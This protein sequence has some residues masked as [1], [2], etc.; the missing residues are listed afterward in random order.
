MVLVLVVAVGTV[1]LFTS[2]GTSSAL[3]RYIGNRVNRD[4]RLFSTV[5]VPYTEDIAQ[6]QARI[7]EINRVTGDIIAV[8][9][10]DGKIIAATDRTLIGQ[11]RDVVLPTGLSE[12]EPIFI[13]R[14]GPPF[15][16]VIS[17]TGSLTEAYPL[18]PYGPPMPIGGVVTAPLPF[19]GPVSGT[20]RL[21]L[22]VVGRN[23]RP[24]GPIEQ[25]LIGSV[26]NALL[27]AVGL[28]GLAA[29]L[30]TI[31]LS[32]RILGPVES[33]T[34]AARKMEQGDLGQRVRVR[35][36]DEIGDLAHAFNSMSEGLTRL[37]Q[38]RRNMV[39][40]VAHELR[41]PI[42]NIR[43]YLEAV[44]DGVAKPD[45]QLINSL[46]EEVMMLNRL[47]DDLQE[48]ALAE[49][50]QLRLL[51]Q[52]L[53]VGQAVQ[54]AVGVVSLVAQSKGLTLRA[55][56]AAGLPKIEADPERIGQILRNLLN[57]AITHTQAGEIVVGVQPVAA[58]VEISV[59]DTGEGI[60]AGHL[61]SIFER[62]Y[63][64]DHSRTRATGGAGLGLAVVRQLVELHG[65]TV[66]VSSEVGVG[67][68]F[69]VTLPVLVRNAGVG[70]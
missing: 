32:R 23:G 39:N 41:T 50:G 18:P 21:A 65:G 30:L 58:A 6:M 9:T 24:G 26:N 11:Q 3:D 53:D 14:A 5:L 61:P 56:L 54:K 40:D 13:A 19:G 15:P 66:L 47:V 44:Q 62:F 60:A 27:L 33:L 25:A 63:R 36:K 8:A 37:E 69:T 68:T 57:N 42:T 46:H 70:D 22:M 45:P 43:G 67:T 7:D 34:A 28:A 2:R 55:E 51:R 48:L 12:Q 16:G 59:R 52:P 1:A 4:Q 38:L 49:A 29:L 64:V 35:S 31:L 20:G 17:Y 10:E